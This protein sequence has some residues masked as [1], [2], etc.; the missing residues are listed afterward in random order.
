MNATFPTVR[1]A[2]TVDNL[3]VEAT[4]AWGNRKVKGTFGGSV[5]RERTGGASASY[6]FK[7]RKLTWYTLQ[8]PDQG[9]AHVTITDNANPVDTVVN[10]YASTTSKKVP[11]AFGGLAKGKHTITITVQGGLSDPSATDSFVSIDA[12]QVGTNT[13]V[14]TPQPS[15]R[16][17]D[18]F[19]YSYTGSPG[20]SSRCSSAALRSRG[21]HCSVRT[22]ASPRC[23]STECP[24]TRLT[25]SRAATP[26]AA[27]PTVG[28]AT[29]YTR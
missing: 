29:R 26:S 4:Y 9:P 10:N 8:G 3:D 28:S 2:T 18:D 22:T 19:S 5:L 27:S 21:S 6:S 25:Y 1:A 16:W 14:G 11:V 15:S 17:N 23:S 7:G 12:F 13:V 24:S 20:S